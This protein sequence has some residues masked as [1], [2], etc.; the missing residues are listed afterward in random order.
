M[1]TLADVAR[2]R[3]VAQRLVPP[4]THVA[5]VVSWMGCTQAQDLG[6]AR[7]AVALRVG[8]SSYA[9]VHEALDAGTV[10]RSWPMRGTL[11]LVAAPDLGWMLGLTSERQVRQARRRHEELGLTPAVQSRA[12]SIA[13]AALDGC[14]LTRAELMAAWEEGGVDTTGQRGVHLLG[15]LAHRHVVCLGPVRGG[16]Q[17][18]VRT[19]RWIRQPRR[20]EREEAVVEWAV[21]YFRSHGP[22]TLRDFLWWTKLLVSEVRPLLPQVREV[23]ASLTIDGTEYLLDP[24]L[25]DAYA[26][27]RRATAAPM[28]LP[29][30]DEILI[31]YTDR[32]ALLGGHDLERVVPGGNGVFL[33]LVV[34]RGQVVGTW[35]RPRKAGESVQVTAFGSLPLALERRLP[36][37]TRALPTR[38]GRV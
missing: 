34:Q 22:A 30:F 32:S 31:G 13:T 35:R 20:L 10:V 29:A 19:D 15:L 12:E 21:R 5:D 16:Q 27:H 1:T 28:L 37:L 25:P 33:P 6:A 38:N 11:H 7:T 2:M 23:L 14:G 36:A 3:L 9:P 4:A 18:V 26:E 8:A 17:E 24:A